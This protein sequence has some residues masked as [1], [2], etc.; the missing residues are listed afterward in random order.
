MHVDDIRIAFYHA[1]LLFAEGTEE[2]FHQ[3][4]VEESSVLVDPCHFEVGEV[5]HHCLWRLCG[6]YGALV[7]VEIDEYV[8]GV[9]RFA[10]FRHIA[11]GQKDFAFV[12]AV[13]VH[14]EVYGLYYFQGVYLA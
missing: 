1:H 13:E 10:A 11:C 5:A 8:E 2:V 9:A 4:P 14:A 12:A 6:G 7:L 3:S